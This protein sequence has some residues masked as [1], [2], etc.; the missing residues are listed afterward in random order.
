MLLHLRKGAGKR[1]SEREG[2]GKQAAAC[3]VDRHIARIDGCGD[4]CSL[5]PSLQTPNITG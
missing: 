4:G 3:R 5:E 1:A 2:V